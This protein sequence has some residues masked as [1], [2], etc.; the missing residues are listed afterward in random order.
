M[1]LFPIR[2][3]EYAGETV[4]ILALFRACLTVGGTVFGKRR[5]VNVTNRYVPM[6]RESTMHCYI[7]PW[8]G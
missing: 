6:Y 4:I 7:Y 2:N 1:A 5:S 8:K 3:V